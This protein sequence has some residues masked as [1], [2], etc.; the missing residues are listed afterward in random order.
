MKSLYWNRYRNKIA[1][2]K[3]AQQSLSERCK[4]RCNGNKLWLLL[5]IRLCEERKKSYIKTWN[6]KNEAP[7]NTSPADTEKLGKKARDRA[8]GIR[9]ERQVGGPPRGLKCK[10]KRKAGYR[11]LIARA[12][13][14]QSENRPLNYISYTTNT[15][16]G[17]WHAHYFYR[18]HRHM[19]VP[20]FY[21]PRAC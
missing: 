17:A 8:R 11:T 14:P 19:R 21:R 1:I 7:S 16:P 15:V 9:R 13:M 20:Q 3:I 5:I 6:E 10:C 2:V 12:G 4:S 18:R